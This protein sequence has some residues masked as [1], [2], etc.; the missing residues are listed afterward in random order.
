MERHFRRSA[1]FSPTT[2]K[3]SFR[4]PLSQAAAGD[5]RGAERAAQSAPKTAVSFSIAHERTH[6]MPLGGRS[7]GGRQ[8]GGQDGHNPFPYVGVAAG[9]GVAEGVS[10]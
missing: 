6:R 8:H 1:I 2:T 9:I 10:V 7:A 4:H 5:F 3:V